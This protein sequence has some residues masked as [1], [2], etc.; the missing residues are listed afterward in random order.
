MTIFDLAIY[1]LK[2]M[3][4]SL[5]SIAFRAFG[6]GYKT[7]GRVVLGF[8]VFILYMAIVPG[9]LINVM[10]YGEFTHIS[11]IV[12]IIGNLSIL[13]FTTDSI[14]K[15]IFLHLIQSG[16]T[17]ILSIILN[18]VRTVLGLSYPMLLV[19][20]L[21][22]SALIYYIAIRYWAK[23]L[24]YMADLI[25]GSVAP[26]LALSIL[27][28]IIV[29]LIPVYP[30]QNFANHPFFCTFMMLAIEL[31]YLIYI[32]LLYHNL[33]TINFLSKGELKNELLQSEINSYKTFLDNAYQTRHDLRHHDAVLLAKLEEG[34][35]EEAKS[36]LQSHLITFNETA[37]KKFCNN[38]TVNIVLRIY[39]NRAHDKNISFSAHVNIPSEFGLK[40]PEIGSLLGNL[41]ENALNECSKEPDKN[42]YIKLSMELERNQILLEIRNSLF[43]PVIFRNGIP[44]SNNPNGGIGT[45]SIIS[46]IKTYNG[47]VSFTN[48][49]DE[50]I[51][52]IIIPLRNHY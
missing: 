40:D 23:P 37:L 5:F 44:V 31:C 28:F 10:G 25:Q 1:L 16:V 33:Y 34:N 2:F 51:A 4:P 35:I 42:P 32:Y 24:R 17:T 48:S 41:L 22:F 19:L 38:S 12:I 6:L 49:S 46:T 15:T 3:I 47:M 39:E 26:Y 9:Y 50:F 20:L 21:I 29:N 36:Y 18:M 27:I 14:G 30:M 52:R 13:I 7:K 45:R 11:S 8:L 43:T